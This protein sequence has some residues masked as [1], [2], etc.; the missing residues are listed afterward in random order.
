MK[1]EYPSPRR[2]STVRR[3]LPWRT[4]KSGDQSLSLSSTS[5]R[6]TTRFSVESPNGD[7]ATALPA[8]AMTGTGEIIPL[9]DGD[10]VEGSEEVASSLITVD[11]VMRSLSSSLTASHVHG[12]TGSSESRGKSRSPTLGIANRAERGI[13][14]TPPSCGTRQSGTSLAA[15]PLRNVAITWGVPSNKNVFCVFHQVGSVRWLSLYNS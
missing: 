14:S 7:D 12:A 11:A 10:A 8:L 1:V 3:A 15:T 13:T 5:G 9:T 2:L 6:T 4:Q